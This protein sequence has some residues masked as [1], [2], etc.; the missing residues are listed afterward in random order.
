MRPFGSLKELEQRRLRAME[1]IQRG[2]L[3]VQVAEVLGVDRRS[4]RRW[5]AFYRTKGI[6]GLTT[7][8]FGAKFSRSK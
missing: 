2:M 3:P 7:G 5:K 6:K 4:V 1:M 8:P